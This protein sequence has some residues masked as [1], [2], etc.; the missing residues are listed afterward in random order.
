MRT[1]GFCVWCDS[2]K[3]ILWRQHIESDDKI[4]ILNGEVGMLTRRLAEKNEENVQLKM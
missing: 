3:L 4:R 2:S 1:S